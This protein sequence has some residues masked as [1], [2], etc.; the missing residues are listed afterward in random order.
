MKIIALHLL[1]LAS[2]V[3]AETP[4]PRAVSITKDR[5]IEETGKS[6]YRRDETAFSIVIYGAHD[7]IGTYRIV[8]VDRA[9]KIDELAVFLKAFYS[10]FPKDA[11]T[12]DKRLSAPVPLPNI[13][14]ASGGWTETKQEGRS[15]VTNLSKEYGIA[16]YYFGIVP[17]YDISFQTLKG[18]P[19]YEVACIE[20]Y[21]KRISEI[22]AT[23]I[24]EREQDGTGQPA[25]RPLSDSE[26][27]DKPQ[28][29][30][31]GRSR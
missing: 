27:S 30:A 12:A 16:L 28:P 8:G 17:G 10:G 15:L 19:L 20:Y 13:L 14:Y 2:I 11:V 9:M 6:G 3:F 18:V 7:S 25:T 31:E 26:G 21:Q 4:D 23:I 29:E 1:I 5:A 22:A 24:K